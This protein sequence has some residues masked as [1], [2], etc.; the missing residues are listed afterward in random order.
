[1]NIFKL[2]YL[3]IRYVK[4]NPRCNMGGTHVK[5]AQ[6]WVRAQSWKQI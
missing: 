3:Y 2:E 6:Q 5:C 4:Y 1:M